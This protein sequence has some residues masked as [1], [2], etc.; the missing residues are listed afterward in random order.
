[1]ALEKAL[2]YVC[3][4]GVF[5]LPFLVLY[6]ANSMFFPF[7][8]GK[9]FAFRIIVEI[10]AGAWI[11]L[12]L[13]NPAYRPRRTWLLWAFSL[14]VLWMAI[15]DAFG[16]YPFK[17]FFS[18]YERMEGWIT[19]AH[20]LTYFVVAQSIL[21]TEKLWKQWWH[22]SLG[23]SLIVAFIGLLQLAGMVAINQSGAR[24]DARIG[25]STY[26]GVYMLFHVFIAVLYL[27]RAWV[28]KVPGKRLGILFGYGAVIA[29]NSFIL[30]FTATRGAILG[31]VGGAAFS[32]LLLVLMA[33]R[34]RIAWRAGGAVVAVLLV[35]AGGFWAVREQTWVQ[36]IEPLF[37]LKEIAREGFPLARQLNIEMA[38]EGF[39]ERPFLG[40]G[41]ENYAAVFDKNYDP[42]MYAQEQWFDRTH[43]IVFDWL[44]AGGI[45]GLLGYLALH[46][47]AL[48]AVWRSGAFALYERAVLSGLFAGY[49][50]YLLFTF[51]NLTSYILF[52][53]LLAYITV[54]AAAA[55]PTEPTALPALSRQT[56][57]YVALGAIVLTWGIAWF[58]NAHMIS[59]N[60]ML[61]QAISSQAGGAARNLEIFQ[62]AL[63]LKRTG[64]QEVRE[65]FSQATLS[66]IAAE[67]VPQELKLRFFEAA[68][69]AM[70]NQTNEA[71]LNARAPFFLGV[72]LNR[73][74]AFADAE[75]ALKIALERSPKKQGILFE[76]GLNAF[77][78]NANDEALGYFKTA[79]ELEPAYMQARVAYA[80]ALIQTSNFEEAE[81]IARPFFESKA[82]PAEMYLSLAG[83]YAG[84]NRVDRAVEILMLL[85]EAK[86]ETGVQ[87]DAL[88]QQ[89]RSGQT[90]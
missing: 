47:F 52:V 90:L 86:P 56:L 74:S 1:M 89:V 10:M 8:S 82:G 31:L 59:A 11:A 14:W 79:Y 66:A 13:V 29:L 32:A 40:W 38:I 62:E 36:N 72:L 87:V 26:L 78:R 16:V 18:N 50:F 54:R 53:A 85:K 17:S 15:A 37:R 55:E 67:N 63:A 21:N 12:A 88:I 3:L 6:V 81:N 68:T 76:L 44:I 49:F 35:L 83:A 45:F 9:N 4:A 39:K 33:P 2:R 75:T 70:M 42:R 25:N 61:I 7:I 71:P 80:N 57:P 28:E 46:F 69:T 19:I 84:V 34:S 77:A 24:L 60:R 64:S 58:V 30:F 23:V 41:Q 43:N 22:T 48:L 27:G 51:D 5:A 73:V 20:L 65:Q